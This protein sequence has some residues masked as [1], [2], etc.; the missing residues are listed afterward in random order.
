VVS[1]MQISLNP[2]NR[3]LEEGEIYCAVR[4]EHGDDPLVIQGPCTIFRSP[5]VHPG[6]RILGE[7]RRP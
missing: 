6:T 5:A 7:I 4:K 2:P 1:L 3:I